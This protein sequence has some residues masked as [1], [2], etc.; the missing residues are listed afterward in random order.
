MS[1]FSVESHRSCL[2]FTVPS[3]WRCLQHKG[4]CRWGVCRSSPLHMEPGAGGCCLCHSWRM[5][6]I[7]S[8]RQH[9]DSW[10][11]AVWDNQAGIFYLIGCNNFCAKPDNFATKHIRNAH[12]SCSASIP[13]EESVFSTGERWHLRLAQPFL[14][15]GFEHS[16]FWLTTRIFDSLAL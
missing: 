4:C 15:R 5:S 2:Y 1:V 3:S 12:V 16:L 14:Q 8:R 9:S 13:C 11:R 10:W 7:C 6:L